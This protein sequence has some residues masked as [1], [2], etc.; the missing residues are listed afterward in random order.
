MAREQPP[1]PY[2][3][4]P[5]TDHADPADREA[6]SGLTPAQL[7]AMR[8]AAPLT[9]AQFQALRAPVDERRRQA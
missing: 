4:P 3:V 5:V 8:R 1:G 9:P 2:V 7:H 6:A